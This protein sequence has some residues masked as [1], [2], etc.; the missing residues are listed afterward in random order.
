[1]YAKAN[2]I[3]EGIGDRLCEDALAGLFSDKKLAKFAASVVKAS[4]WKKRKR[5]LSE[6]VSGGFETRSLGRVSTWSYKLPNGKF[7]IRYEDAEDVPYY[8]KPG[9]ELEFHPKGGRAVRVRGP[10]FGDFYTLADAMRAAS[11]LVKG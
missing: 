7:T 8:D 1:M 9:Y 5:E 10:A 3:L 11:R 2:E 6:P 4:R